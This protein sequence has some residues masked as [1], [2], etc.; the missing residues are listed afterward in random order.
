MADER[1]DQRATA[2]AARRADVTAVARRP[3]PRDLP[4]QPS[5][6]S[7]GRMRTRL[8]RIGTRGQPSN[9]VLEPLF[10]AVRPTTR[11]PTWRCS[12][13]PTRPPSGCHRGQMR[14]SGEPVHH[15][16][17]RGDDDPRRARHDRADAGR[18]AAPRHGRG[19]AVHARGRAPGLRRRGRPARRRRHQARQG[20]STARSRAGRDDPQDDRGDEP[21]HPGARHQ[22][23]RPAAQHAHAALPQ[24]VDRRS[25]RPARPSRSSRRWPTGSA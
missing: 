8:A 17:A 9:P 21:R 12:S 11:R 7:A 24:A 16:P 2:D 20:R 22:A 14:K 1:V 4:R 18:L 10:R 3:R 5:A 25:A 19:H 13:A 6:P 23:R 15:P